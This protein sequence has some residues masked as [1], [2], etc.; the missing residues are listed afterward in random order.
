MQASFDVGVLRFFSKVLTGAL[1]EC[2]EWQ[3]TRAANGYGRFYAAGNRRVAAHRFIYEK[4]FGAAPKHLCVCHSCDNRACV[5]PKHLFLGSHLDNARDRN[6]K[7][8]QARPKGVLNP[9]AILSEQQ[10]RKIFEDP[11][12][13]PP[14]A[15]EHCVSPTTVQ[16]IKAGKRWAHVTRGLK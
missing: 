8:R 6:R 2:W 4:M 9:S 12:S 14:I 10:V 3:G 5:N 11:R 15:A 16:L 7:N 1:D 13:S